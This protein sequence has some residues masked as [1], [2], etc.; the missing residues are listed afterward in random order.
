MEWKTWG[1]EQSQLTSSLNT[2]RITALVI[3]IIIV[4]IIFIIFWGKFRPVVY[5]IP[6]YRQDRKPNTRSLV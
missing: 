5:S 2:T 6:S 1:A 4:V 3:I